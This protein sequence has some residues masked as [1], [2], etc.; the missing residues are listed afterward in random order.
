M[1]VEETYY[2]EGVSS[3]MNSAKSQKIRFD[4]NE[5]V[6]TLSPTNT[7]ERSKFDFASLDSNKLGLFYSFADQVNKDIFN[8]IG[9]VSLDDYIGDPDDEF[10][11]NYPLLKQFSEKYWKKYTNKSDINSYI[12]IFSQFDF[13]LFKQ[14]KQLL[15]ERIDEAT[16]LLI[17]P[18]ALERNKIA[19]TKRPSIE[20]PM[21]DVL[22]R[23]IEPSGSGV[24]DPNLIG[25][26]IHPYT[27]A[28]SSLIPLREAVIKT[29]ATQS[30]IPQDDLVITGSRLS[31]IFLESIF[32]YE[33]DASGSRLEKN[34][35]LAVSESLG[36]YSRIDQKKASYM[37][38]NFI[39]SDNPKF[40]G[41]RITGPGVNVSSNIVELNFK[42][43]VEV[44]ETNP[45]QIFYTNQPEAPNNSNI[46]NPGNI[47]IR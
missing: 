36:L 23:E 10:K 34:F 38:D 14:I 22:I 35:S 46:I 9:D 1:P 4:S 21:V 24:V 39:M 29:A 28:S 41:S 20:T 13:A 11:N 17:E 30:L 43:V 45:N 25:K 26:I 8:Q 3:G 44:F 15:A 32:V 37:D 5:L 33:G 19:L 42:P 31:N 18:H 12:R 2:I 16:G 6:R 40:L 7:A 47:I 27:L